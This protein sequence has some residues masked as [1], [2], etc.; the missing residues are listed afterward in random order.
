[1]ISGEI[2]VNLVSEMKTRIG[3]NRIVRN[4]PQTKFTDNLP[5]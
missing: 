2:F 1:M 3:Q 4:L 5:N